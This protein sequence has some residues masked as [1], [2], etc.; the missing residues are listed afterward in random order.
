MESRKL[1]AWNLRRVRVSRG[2][3][4]ENLAVDADV[5]RS[6]VGR[7]ERGIENPTVGVLDRL[8]DALSVHVSELFLQPRA[9][10]AAP[11]PLRSGRHKS[12]LAPSRTRSAA[13]SRG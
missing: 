9:G 8:A 6:Y 4:Q 13:K 1:V 5:D 10:E 11:K 12:K 2:L 7:L 3:S